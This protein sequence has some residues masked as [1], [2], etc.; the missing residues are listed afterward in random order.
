MEQTVRAPAR[1]RWSW[2]VYD[3]ANTIWSMNVASLYFVPWL[4]IDLG[5][6]SSATMWA[7]AVSSVMVALA[8]P[9]LGAVSDARRRRKPWVITFTLLAV[10]ATVAIG[11][12]GQYGLPLYGEAVVGGS[13][14]PADFQL[15]GTWLLVIGAAFTIA[16]F[17]YQAVNPFYNAMMTELVPP[18]EYGRLSGLGT[19]IGYI[20]TIVG[21]LLVAPFFNGVLPVLGEVPRDVLAWLRS[22]VPGTAHGGR[23]S[24]FVP[25]ALLFLIFALPLFLFCRDRNPA[26]P[27]T[28]IRVRDAFQELART[29]RESRQHP[30]ALRFILTSLIY[31]DGVGTITVVLG[32]YAIKAVGFTQDAVN[33]V[34]VILPITAVLGSFLT[35][36]LVDRI[37]PKRALSLVLGSWV[38]LLLLLAIFPSKTAFWVIGALIGL[39]SFGGTPTAERPMLL[40]L[41][42][43]RDAGRYFSLLLL[44]ARAAAFVGPLIWGYTI[45]FLEPRSGTSAAYRT[46]IMTIAGFF[47]LALVLLQGVPDTRKSRRT[48]DRA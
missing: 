29:F 17:A 14:R 30:G 34:F 9:V 10:A 5:A 37:G 41:V 3:F 12:V 23:V 31:Q 8:I 13:P 47:L 1:E 25:T 45:D 28:P 11:M 7:T 43:E 35:G 6:S 39:A 32:V 48:A 38:A 19:G 42:P 40:S 46:G 20:G 24:T 44:S 36:W 2:A 26:P 21:V 15:A 16:N 27:G 4:V 18:H 22:V 33:T